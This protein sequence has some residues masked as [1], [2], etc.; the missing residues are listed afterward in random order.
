M[1]TE[2]RFIFGYILITYLLGVFLSIKIILEN[3]DPIKT[4]T[5]LLIFILFPGGGVLIYAIFGINLRK[6][7]LLLT[8]DI[9]DESRNLFENSNAINEI[10]DIEKE[11]FED[12]VEDNSTK[13]YL[14][15]LLLNNSKF[16][17]TKNNEIEIF[18]DGV[19]KFE[20]LFKDIENAK[21]YIHLE[22]FIIKD[23]EVGEKLKKL[24]IK[25]A[26]EGLEIKILYDKIGCFRFILNPK[27]IKELKNNNIS[28]NYFK[29]YK[30][31]LIGGSINY[32][33]HRKIV[34][35]DG[36]TSYLGGINV[37]DEYL[38]KNKKFG[39][40]RDTHIKVFGSCTHMLQ[41]NFSTDW[42]FSTKEILIS[43]KYFP[44]INSTGKSTIQVV[45]SGPDS[46]LESIY[47]SYFLIISKAK[48]SIRIETPYF[49]PDDTLLKALK[50]AILSGVKVEIIFPKIADHK[51]VNIA[52]YS[53]FD[54]ILKYGGKIY[55][56]EKGFIHSK[57]IIIDEEI[58]STG[59]CNIDIR[60]F[61]VNFEINAFIY[62]KE[63]IDKFIL[64]FNDDINFSKELKFE[65]FNKRNKLTRFKESFCRLLSPLL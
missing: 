25:K 29:P 53:Y 28:V 50:N 12:R 1:I 65:E 14:I 44:K 46:D 21:D 49:I 30:F 27:Y 33:N 11:Q 52:S 15:N 40:W 10:I 54:E 64:D 8:K 6:R 32:R 41:M 38:G 22:Y 23:C 63:V 4:M 19:E 18:K 35:I 36:H 45:S 26:K 5:W 60:S 31:P 37:G 59:S 56:Y 20:S 24:L 57:V 17:Y 16:P 58:V 2:N 13:K 47:Y 61:L 48:K 9:F 3:R 34:I 62:D 55:L 7:R 42:Y 51:I 39:Y 43:K